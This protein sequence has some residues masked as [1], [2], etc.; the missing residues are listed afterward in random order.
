MSLLLRGRDQ[1]RNQERR[2]T[3]TSARSPSAEVV[4]GAMR[5]FVAVALLAWSGAA[6]GVETGAIPKL[7]MLELQPAEPGEARVA[8]VLTNFLVQDLA[9][10]RRFDVISQREIATLVSLERQR[11]LL[12]CNDQ[13]SSCLSELAGALGA[14]Y[15]VSGTVTRIGAEWRVAIQI[16]QSAQAKAAAREMASA[17]SEEALTQMSRDLALRLAHGLPEGRGATLNEGL[18]RGMWLPAAIAGVAFGAG[19][20]TMFTLAQ[21]EAQRLRDGDASISGADAVRA[22]VQRGELYQ[23]VALG[24]GEAAIV[25]GT[26]SLGFA[27]FGIP[28][29][30]VPRVA[31]VPFGSSIH[32]VGRLP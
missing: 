17:P 24:L 11:E 3:R 15:V 29:R 22:V 18:A 16:L 13:A 30:D 26:C 20:A 27:L 19:S 28:E 14:K 32:L 21:G 7:V 23:N 4:S 9:K 8:Q 6:V 2:A 12:G 10:T 5:S 31:I 25:A 1:R